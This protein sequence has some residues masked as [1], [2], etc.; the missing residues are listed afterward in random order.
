MRYPMRQIGQVGTPRVEPATN[1]LAHR[2][3]VGC[4]PLVLVGHRIRAYV[5]VGTH[6]YPYAEQRY[7]TD[8]DAISARRLGRRWACRCVDG[9]D[10]PAVGPLWQRGVL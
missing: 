5:I 7:L 2:A 1:L 6:S 10:C 8:I 3:A 4:A 9:R